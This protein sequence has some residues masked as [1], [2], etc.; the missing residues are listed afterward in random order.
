[1]DSV[2][3]GEPNSFTSY[4]SHVSHD[5]YHD[6]VIYIYLSVIYHM[7]P[8]K[9]SCKRYIPIGFY[10]HKDVQLSHLRLTHLYVFCFSTSPIHQK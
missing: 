6:S 2:D 7:I 9:S 8:C 10:C 3:T 4:I 1:M 5:I